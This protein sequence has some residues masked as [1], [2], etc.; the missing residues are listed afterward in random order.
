MTPTA[1]PPSFHFGLHRIPARQVGATGLDA[2]LNQTAKIDTSPLILSARGCA[3]PSA[4]TQSATTL[5]RSRERGA[6][7]EAERKPAIL[8]SSLR[9][10]V[11]GDRAGSN[12][13][14]VNQTKSNQCAHASRSLPKESFA[15]DPDDPLRKGIQS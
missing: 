14:K 3:I 2:L 9:F 10:G 15:A 8:P 5:S 11:A 13:I 1:D 12:R 4:L 6:S 7:F